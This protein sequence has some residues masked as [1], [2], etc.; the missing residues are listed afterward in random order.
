VTAKDG[1]L[2][3]FALPAYIPWSLPVGTGGPL[4]GFSATCYYSAK[5]ILLGRPASERLVP[6]G[7]IAA[8]WG[9]TTI[10]A[11]APPHVNETCAPLFPGGTFGCGMD[12]APCNASEI[13]NAMLRPISGPAGPAMPLAAFIWVRAQRPGRPGAPSLNPPPPPAPHTHSPRTPPSRPLRASL[14]V[15]GRE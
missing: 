12:H 10:K 7:L 6:L 14:A 13:Y 4:L 2:D 15:P 3:D 5:S 11:H 9:G 1:P 8:P